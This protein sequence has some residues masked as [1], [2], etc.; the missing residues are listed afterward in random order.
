MHIIPFRTEHLSEAS[1]LF[2]ENFRQL[3]QA[4]PETPAA[5]EDLAFVRERLAGLFGQCPGLVALD[6]DQLVGYLGWFLVDDLRGT[7]RKGAYCPE[8]GHATTERNRPAIYRG[9]YRAAA[10][11]WTEAGCKMHALTL[12]ASDQVGVQ[13]WFWNGFGLTVVDGIR[14]MEPL[15][16]FPSPQLPVRKAVAAEAEALS[17]LDAEHCRHYSEAPIFMAPRE[18]EAPEQRVAFMQAGAN[19]IWAAYD[20][21]EPIGF[22]QFEADYDDACTLVRSA[23]RIAVTGAYVRPEYRGLKLAQI[24]L[25]S[26]LQ[27]YAR[28]GFQRCSVDFESFN[29][30]AAT[31]WMRH[32]KPVCYSLIRVP[33]SV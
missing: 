20:G 10:A 23:D 19:S 30:E 5:F 22:I 15:G 26:A 27:D 33:E 8:W 12:L 28:A 31:F 1:E 32:F 25:S 6:G 2:I 11:L 14:G 24:I 21:D 9:L 4:V 29:P 17:R 18:G 16:A 13:V 3:R 7:G